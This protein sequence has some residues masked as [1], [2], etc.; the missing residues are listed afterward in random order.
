MLAAHL[1]L[2]AVYAD[3]GKEEEARSHELEI[4]KIDPN[5]SIQKAKMANRWK[6]REYSERWSSSLRKAGLPD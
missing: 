2:C 5:F 4:L 3:L 6:D 1:G